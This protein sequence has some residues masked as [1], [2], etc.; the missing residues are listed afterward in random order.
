MSRS[1]L[2]TQ[3]V[4]RRSASKLLKNPG[5][6]LPPLLIPLFMFAAVA[7]AL[8]S[9]DVGYYNYT[10]FTFVFV[11]YMGAMFVGVFTGIEIAGDFGTGIGARLM[12]AA[13]RRMAIIG[14]YVVM[15]FVRGLIAVVVIGGIAVATGMPI[16]GGVL[17]ML[18][19]VALALLLNVATTLY[20]AGMALRVQSAGGGVLIFIPVFMV[21]LLTP[22]F[23]P[24]DLLDGWLHTAAS[25][26][27]LTPAMEAGR[28]FMANTSANLG[29]AFGAT[30]GLVAVFLLWAFTGMRKAERGP[31][32][33]RRRRRRPG[34][35][36][37]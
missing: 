22:A 2:V 34:P 5:P 19:L 15:S 18:G 4:A 29:L 3:A 28:D 32:E 11:V 35:Q 17:D 13:P 36:T 33:P 26:N 31:S 10:A 1:G 7:G 16:R 14:G 6:G 25:I 27:P 23:V 24:R 9:I 20:G 12:L 37:S 30:A 21:M 8:S